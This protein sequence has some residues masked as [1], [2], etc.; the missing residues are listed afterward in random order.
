MRPLAV[1]SALTQ[2]QMP[3]LAAI[4]RGSQLDAGATLFHE[5]DPAVEVFTV[6]SGMLKLSKLLP[7]GRR[8][9]TGFLTPGDYLGLAF[10]ERYVYSAEA[11]T[12]VRICRFSR[13]AFLGL[14]EQFPALEKELKQ[15]ETQGGGSLVKEEVTEE[16]IAQVVSRW[17]GI[18]VDKML[19]GE[20]EK[21]LKMEEAI[22][23][24]VVG[25]DE[26]VKAVSTE[27]SPKCQ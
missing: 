10:A 12:P 7:D 8:Q 25:Q 17:T 23:A 5:D 20:R 26:A 11:V 22:G 4:A 21:L 19:A 24:R 18:P 15:L 13:P 2:K 6:T 9:I 3:C 16:N 1:C 14:L 27:K